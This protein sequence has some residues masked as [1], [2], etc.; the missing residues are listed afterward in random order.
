MDF[1][2]SQCVNRVIDS[3]DVRVIRETVPSKWLLD[4][5]LKWQTHK[6]LAKKE[7]VD[8]LFSEIPEVGTF[9]LILGASNPYQFALDCPEI[10]HIRIWNLE[11]W[12]SAYNGQTGQIYISFAS[13]Y[14]QRL[15]SQELE[16]LSTISSNASSR[17][18][19]SLGSSAF[20]S[21]I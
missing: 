12:R 4:Q 20:P 19:K 8:P 10:C 14:L 6:D 7:R 9:R 13:V 3:L 11:K 17:I 15:V 16:K 18:Q 21:L 5:S 2:K 1:E